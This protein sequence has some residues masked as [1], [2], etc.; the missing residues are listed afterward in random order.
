M[1]LNM[2]LMALSVAAIASMGSVESGTARSSRMIFASEFY[3]VR[4]EQP[5]SVESRRQ[6]LLFRR[7]A[8]NDGQRPHWLVERRELHWRGGGWIAGH[9]WIDS[10]DCPGVS[11]LLAQLDRLPS[12]AIRGPSPISE[13]ARIPPSHTP[14]VTLE[15]MP[16]VLAGETVRLTIQDSTGSVATWWFEGA[17]TL[18]SCWRVEPPTIDGGVV[19]S[20]VPP[21]S[22]PGG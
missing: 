6:A 7:I 19:R 15:V 3:R 9:D 16:A 1:M 18:A 13:P 22:E 5:G 4:V 2:L 11:S 17:P 10:R 14:V 8:Q 20:A 12:A 21:L